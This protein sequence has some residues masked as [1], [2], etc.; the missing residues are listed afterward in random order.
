MQRVAPSSDR[1]GESKTDEDRRIAR[2]FGRD[3][4]DGDRRHGHGGLTYHSRFWQPVVPTF[5]QHFGLTAGSS[6]LDV[7]CGK[8]F[9]L[10]DLAL[11]VPGIIVKGV[12]ISRTSRST[13]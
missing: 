6:L 3:F 5:V 8:G 10:H 11:L 12:D 13:S 2:Q 4:F 9:M 1:R 7:G